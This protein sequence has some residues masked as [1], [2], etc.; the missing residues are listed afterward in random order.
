MIHVVDLIKKHGELTVLNGA[1]L[2]VKAGEVAGIVGP[3]GSGDSPLVRCINGLEDF[4]GGG[5]TVREWTLLPEGEDRDRKR[6]LPE[7][8]R[9]VGMV[10]QQFNLFP[11][12]AALENVMSGP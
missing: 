6:K 11:H 1:T 8:R 12:M 5:V 3:S 7:L 10:F 9:R 2:E 4:Q